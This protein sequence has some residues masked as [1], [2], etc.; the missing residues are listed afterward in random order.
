MAAGRLEMDEYEERVATVAEAKTLGELR[1]LFKDLPAPYPAFMIPAMQ[2]P[3][4]M[5]PPMMMARPWSW[6]QAETISLP[7]AL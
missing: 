5:G 2:L 7:L 4:P 1:P 6:R 3:P